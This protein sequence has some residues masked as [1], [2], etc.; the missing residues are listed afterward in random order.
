MALDENHLRR[1]FDIT[2]YLRLFE[3]KEKIDEQKCRVQ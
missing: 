1:L 2:H 3:E